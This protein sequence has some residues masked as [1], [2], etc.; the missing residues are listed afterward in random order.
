MQAEVE[1]FTIGVFGFCEMAPCNDFIVNPFRSVF[2]NGFGNS[3]FVSRFRYLQVVKSKIFSAVFFIEM[4]V[5]VIIFKPRM[6][7][8]SGQRA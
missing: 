4:Q 6:S 5:K 1:Y 8:P 3:V 2:T 7:S